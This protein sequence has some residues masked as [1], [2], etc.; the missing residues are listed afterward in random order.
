M[1]GSVN[2]LYLKAGQYSTSKAIPVTSGTHNIEIECKGAAGETVASKALACTPSEINDW[3]WTEINQK[4]GDELLLPS[5]WRTDPNTLEWAECAS[6]SD[7]QT[8]YNNHKGIKLIADIVCE[9]LNL[10]VPGY[11]D[12]IIDLNGHKLYTI[13]QF[14]CE[15]TF[16][17]LAIISSNG[18][19]YIIADISMNPTKDSIYDSFGGWSPIYGDHFIYEGHDHSG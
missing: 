9:S 5:G 15:T 4:I 13:G 18:Y 16:G 14:L 17:G 7:I 2:P 10:N 8:A 1:A 3:G 6:F 12:I 11:Y 19:G